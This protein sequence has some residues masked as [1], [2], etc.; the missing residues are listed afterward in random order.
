[1]NNK[2]TLLKKNPSSRGASC[3]FSAIQT[4]LH[5]ISGQINGIEKMIDTRKDCLSVL[6]QIVAVRK[7]LD[8]VALLV[9]ESEARGCL[10]SKKGG[11]T[12]SDLNRI[13]AALFKAV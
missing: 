12:L 3:D 8:Q 2:R 6:Q 9:L 13:V 7:A 1:M 5:R 10:S 11:Q 4:R